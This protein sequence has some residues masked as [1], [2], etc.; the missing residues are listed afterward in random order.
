[1]IKFSVFYLTSKMST[2]G[3]YSARVGNKLQR[4]MAIIKAESQAC[5]P[6]RR[7]K[8]QV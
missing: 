3:V 1:M 6:D 4:C 8:I 7:P 2:L 5:H